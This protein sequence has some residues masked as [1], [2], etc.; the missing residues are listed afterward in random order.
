MPA[1]FKCKSCGQEHPVP[2]LLTDKR[3][4]DSLLLSSFNLQCPTTGAYR[5]YEKRELVWR[6]ETS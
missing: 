2:F 1:F 5:P 4:F 6:D 3:V